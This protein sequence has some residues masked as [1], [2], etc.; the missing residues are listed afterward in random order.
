MAWL[1]NS[2]SDNKTNKPPAT[3]GGR[4]Q[5]DARLSKARINGGGRAGPLQEEVG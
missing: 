2:P 1:E 5:R 4:Y 3:D